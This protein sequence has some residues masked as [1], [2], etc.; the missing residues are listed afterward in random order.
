MEVSYSYIVVIDEFF[1]N[2]FENGYVESEN[3]VEEEIVFVKE[4]NVVEE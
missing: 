2:G 4:E 1:E 3:V